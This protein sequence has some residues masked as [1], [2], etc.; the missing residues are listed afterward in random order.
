MFKRIIKK[1][2]L[3]RKLYFISKR[4]QSRIR[5][6]QNKTFDRIIDEDYLFE[7]LKTSGVYPG[8]RVI[9]NSTMSKIGFLKEGPKT[10]VDA[11][12][13]YITEDGL[14]VM[15]TYPHTNSYE[16]LE[17][18]KIFDVAVTPSRNGAI[19][20]YFRKSM[21][22]FRSIHPTHPLCAWG[23][24]AEYIMSGHELSKSRYDKYSPYK[25]LLDLDVKIFLI[26]VNLNH[27]VMFRAIDDLYEDYP[28]NPFIIN[29]YYKVKVIG[30]QGEVIDV[31][32]TCDDP[33]YSKERNNM[34]IFPYIKHKIKF[35]MLGGA[36]TWV[37]SSQDLF[38]VQIECAKKGI[39]PYHKLPWKNRE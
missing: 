2:P 38:N 10:F 5:L 16:Y 35:G 25:K 15:S 9:I 1:M 36:E 28:L 8:D 37:L 17:N 18:Y 27:A 3:S 22:V 24:D 23:R 12:K 30:H 11:L 14:I 29:K 34:L 39:L 19:S 31:Q 4:F 33:K 7:S 20:E 26:G 13:R 21:N 6:F 32:T